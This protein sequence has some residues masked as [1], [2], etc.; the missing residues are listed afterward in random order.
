MLT[1]QIQAL[2]LK[3]MRYV[4]SLAIE[5]FEC[6]YVKL[7]EERIAKILKLYFSNLGRLFGI[8][9]NVNNVND[10]LNK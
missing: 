2:F 5:W 9:D 10:N 8:N 1:I 3:D 7:N 6:N 4:N